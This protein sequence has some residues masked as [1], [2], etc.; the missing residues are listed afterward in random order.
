MVVAITS[1]PISGEGRREH[2]S[3]IYDLLEQDLIP[4]ADASKSE[5]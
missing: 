4:L 2:Q 1:L 5:K 3:S